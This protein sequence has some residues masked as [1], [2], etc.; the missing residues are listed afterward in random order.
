[1]AL[2]K[3]FIQRVKALA[4]RSFN[5]AENLRALGEQAVKAAYANQDL[6]YAQFMLD[7]LPVYLRRPVAAWFKRAGLEVSP[8]AVGD[9]LYK[10]VCVV[11]PKQQNKA[12]G[13]AMATP[14]VA[15]EQAAAKAKKSKALV[16][17]AHSRAMDALN[18]CA[19]RL[20]TVDAEAAGE[21]R[22]IVGKFVESEVAKARI[23]ELERLLEV[24][25]ATNIELFKR[26]EGIVGTEDAMEDAMEDATP[27]PELKV[28]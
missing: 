13:F 10:V 1:M 19:K 8:P 23:A 28:A 6:E 5:D 14:V 2:A 24:A 11:D 27:L 17:E 16:G 20:D 15:T 4:N 26:V 12:F 25:N 9:T 18:K 3:Q 22:A 21:V 7:V